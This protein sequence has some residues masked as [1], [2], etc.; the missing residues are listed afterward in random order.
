VRHVILRVLSSTALLASTCLA[1]PETSQPP[2]F[3]AAAVRITAPAQFGYAKPG[4]YGTNRYTAMNVSLDLLV[5]LAYGVPFQQISGIDKLGTEHYDLAV[6]AEDGVTL[7]YPALQPRMQ[8]LLE[9][10]FHLAVHKEEKE[11]DG[12][13]LTV[14]KSGPKLRPTTG[15][16]ETG[17][18]YPGGL[19]LANMPL[20]GFASMIRSTV[21]SPV[22]DRSGIAGNYDFEMKFARDDDKDSPLPSFPTALRETFGLRLEKAK[23][24]LEVVVIDHVDKVPTEN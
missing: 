14:A 18:I 9:Q 22:E 11:F 7:T 19:R 6:K 23:V 24:K 4:S 16:S 10:R 5:Q 1:Q 12:Y 2:E 13:A 3:E 8:R 20:A 15:S 21:G 17:S